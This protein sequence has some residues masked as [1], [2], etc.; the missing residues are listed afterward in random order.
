MR[1]DRVWPYRRI[2]LAHRF[3]VSLWRSRRNI[4]A[5]R[6]GDPLGNGPFLA[7][8]DVTYRCN[9]RCQMCQRWQD[10]RDGELTLAEYQKLAR[11]FNRMGVYQLSIAGGE[12][13]LREDIIPIIETF[14]GQGMSVNLCTNGILLEDHSEALCRSG[15]TCITVSVD[16]ATADCHEGIRGAPGSYARIVRGIQSIV[17]HAPGD[18]PVVRTRMTI[19][20]RNLQEI[21]L[22][23]EKWNSIVDDVLVQPVHHAENPCYVGPE[24]ESFL[25]DPDRLAGCLDGTPLGR[26]GYMRQLIESLRQTGQYPRHR[27]YA[28]VLMTRID[29]WGDVYPCLEQHVR[30]GSVR[31]QDFETIW[32]SEPYNLERARIASNRDCT[33]WYNNTALISHYGKWLQRTTGNGLRTESLISTPYT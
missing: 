2:L 28:G 15:V 11:V 6:R 16:G 9:C 33:C 5:V 24:E 26:N 10:G 32:N 27:C 1:F 25:I 19:S 21:R 12:P 8:L 29:P 30:I 18:R 20:N 31:E 7:E 13:L 14:S 4:I 3:V 23:Y 17:Y 22:Y